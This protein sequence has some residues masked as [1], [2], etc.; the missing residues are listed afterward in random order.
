MSFQIKECERSQLSLHHQ[1]SQQPSKWLSSSWSACTFLPPLPL[2]SPD[3]NYKSGHAAFYTFLKVSHGNKVIRSL[4]ERLNV[5]KV[6][7]CP[8]LFCS[9]RCVNHN[10][11]I[12][13]VVICKQMSQKTAK[14]SFNTACQMEP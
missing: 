5:N 2:I 11:F 3:C 12:C 9:T 13:F 10:S 14:L 6:N 4:D 8:C 1:P 7:F